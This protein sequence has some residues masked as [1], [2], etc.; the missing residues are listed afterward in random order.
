LSRIYWLK[1]LEA[2][3]G[4]DLYLLRIIN[5][6]EPIPLLDS[7]MVFITK[8]GYWFF[9]L[10]SIFV[11]IKEKKKAIIPVFLV[12]IAWGLSDASGNLLKH[13]IERPRPFYTVE[14]LR[15]LVGKGKS[16]SF[17]S[18][19]AVTSFGAAMVFTYFFRY[20]RIPVFAVA[21][22]IAFS[23]VYVGVHYPSDIIG[24]ALLGIFVALSVIYGTRKIT[25][26]YRRDH[27]GA[28]FIF[29]S[30]CF[31][32]SRLFYI[33]Y[34][35]LELSPDEAHYWEWSR[36]PDLSYYSKGPLIAYL[37]GLTT[38]IGGANELGVR[39]LAP[40]FLFFSSLII[41]RLSI[42]LYND[43]MI[44]V[45]TGL[46]LQFI[47]L[48][49]AYGII[50]TIDSP[51]IF[52][53]ILSLYLFF[54]AIRENKI[55]WWALLGVSTGLGML[56]KY[57]MAFFYICGAIYLIMEKEKRG[58]LKDLKTYFPLIISLILFLPVLVWN[59]KND[60]VT[61]R[62]TGGHL[63]IYEGLKLRP[64]S[65]LEFI[66]SQ[67]GVITPF[68]FIAFMIAIFQLTVPF[69]TNREKKNGTVT[70]P[71][72]VTSQPIEHTLF[73]VSFSL[74]VL[75]FFLIKTLQ[76]KVQAN[77]PLMAYPAM[78]LLSVA[79]YVNKWQSLKKWMRYLFVLSLAFLLFI[80]PFLYFPEILD[81]PPKL[82]PSSRL[83]GW[84][85]LG[86]K[87]TLL[88]EELKRRGLPFFIVSD[89]YQVSSEIAFYTEG[90]PVTY[91]VNLGRRMNQYDLW[92][93]FHN[94]VHYNAIFVTIGDSEMPGGF[95]ERFSECY[96]EVLKTDVRDY[97][98]FRCYDFKG[99]ERDKRFERY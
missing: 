69:A 98:I 2:N 90:N 86:R 24:G 46:L 35:P 6:H 76:A 95:R 73:L 40:F 41:Y 30:V 20:L 84:K 80:T 33:N 89:K 77:W 12:L 29:L 99:M 25:E 82:D 38:A 55:T 54:K 71:P 49:A 64:L 23:R 63:G 32:I 91:C 88:S 13:L 81:L 70:S 74:P 92:P 1:E 50:M 68:L 51:F 17:P 8:K 53:W 39:F 93:G 61:F 56:A 47:P 26:F 85:D 22:L 52:F 15:V 18:N 37:I 72:T 67:F 9:I 66:G 94:F 31:L 44:G 75:L 96:K 3:L 83:R 14:G 58:L 65:F 57:S 7:L 60:F 87:V 19:H 45:L 62:H 79:W 48:F 5:I 42:E 4:V 16:F 59:I 97:S 11:L 28:L 78:M 43:S 10:L 36:R 27:L 34:G 21:S